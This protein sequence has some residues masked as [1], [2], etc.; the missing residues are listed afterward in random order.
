[1]YENGQIK[2]TRNYKEGNE[3]SE[4]GSIITRYLNDLIKSESYYKDGKLNGKW[5]SWFENG[6]KQLEVNYKD[7]KLNGKWSSWFES[8]QIKS[9]RN[10]KDSKRDGKSTSWNKN[11]QIKS[12]KI[13]KDD[14]L[15]EELVIENHLENL[16]L[17]YISN[18]SAR[19]KTFWR[20]LAAE[21]DWTAEVFVIQD[22]DGNVKAVEVKNAG[23][24][25]SSLAKSFMDS[26]ERAIYKASP[27]PSAPDEAVFDKELYF[28]FSVK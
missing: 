8:G 28:V 24:S 26:I 18:I 23:V 12:E 6:Q 7:G 27:L 11:S 22:R 19:I 3:I 2:S 9:E 20:Y 14:E 21:D 25:N 17:A 1:L 10:Y 13:Y 15:V 4:D 16:K 5:T